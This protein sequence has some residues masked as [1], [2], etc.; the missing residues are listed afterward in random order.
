M[1]KL[2]LG[3][4]D[5]KS[6]IEQDYLY[7]DKT[8]YILELI[9]D[10][11]FLFF[12]R[13]RRFGKSLICSCL[14]YIYQGKKD[15]FKNL[16]IQDKISWELM[17]FPVLFFD[18]TNGDFGT[19]ING[20]F[21]FALKNIFEEFNINFKPADGI[22]NLI[23]LF[24]H[25]K[26]LN[27]KVVIIIDEYDAPLND[28]LNKPNL[29]EANQ[30]FF[31][32]FY[33]I[34][35]S[36]EGSIEKCFVT[37]VSRY[38]QVNLFSGPN[39]I[40]DISFNN[41]YAD[42]CGIKEIELEQY[43]KKYINV[44]ANEFE[45]TKE[46]FINLLKD[47]YN[48]FSFNGISKLFNPYSINLFFKEN[49][50]DYFW[51]KTGGNSIWLH[52]LIQDNNIYY[53]DLIQGKKFSYTELTSMDNI[54]QNPI[55]LLYQTGYLSI[56]EI[57][58]IDTKY[59]HITQKNKSSN[60]KFNNYTIGFPNMEVKEAFA[61]LVLENSM[62]LT[63]TELLD[64]NIFELRKNVINKEVEL[65]LK[66]IETRIFTLIPYQL[67]LKNEAYYHSIFIAILQT[68]GFTT[69]N[70]KSL[71]NGRIDTILQLDDAVLIFEFKYNQSAQIAYN[72]IIEKKYYLPFVYF[73]NKKLG[74]IFLKD[75][76]F[77]GVNLNDN[78]EMSYIFKLYIKNKLIIGF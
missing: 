50:F 15:Y 56:K 68:L 62:E 38:G 44:A 37:G 28:N 74:F 8:S 65:F 16:Y 39:N 36:N 75:I 9:N 54:N 49:K 24:I 1:K 20:A 52:H 12:T 11:K 30:L 72:Q 10:D 51:F 23:S 34:I 64:D 19:N 40:T 48:G 67:H 17:D 63:N 3:I 32:D 42:A 29:F 27:K 61:R 53:S 46:K 45:L 22:N 21:L 66:N 60:A 18:F 41:K 13:P 43:Y 57:E 25:F 59:L 33:K 35:K 71:K 77:I 31:R 7:V 70:E 76:Y 78:K 6:I 69:E 4:Q 58:Q 5:F 26:N 73:E 2:P 47:Y 14:K 55:A